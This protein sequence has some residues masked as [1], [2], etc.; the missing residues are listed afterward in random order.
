MSSPAELLLS[1]PK[2]DDDTRLC[3]AVQRIESGRLVLGG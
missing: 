3:E 1:G 2:G